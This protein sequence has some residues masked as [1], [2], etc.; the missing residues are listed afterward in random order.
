MEDTAV[1]GPGA[2]STGTLKQV[3]RSGDLKQVALLQQKVGLLLA[4]VAQLVV[5]ALQGSIKAGEGLLQYV[6]YASA[7]FDGST[8]RQTETCDVAGRADARRSHILIELGFCSSL[9]T[10][11]DGSRSVGCFCVLAS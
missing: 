6:L 3:A 1:I 5:R 8:T 11:L 7:L 2:C 10:S 4:Q 9:K